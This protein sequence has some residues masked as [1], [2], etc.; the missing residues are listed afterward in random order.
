MT[1]ILNRVGAARRLRYS[2][3]W[4]LL[5]SKIM[6]EAIGWLKVTRKRYWLPC[7]NFY[8]EYT[9]EQ[10]DVILAGFGDDIP[11]VQVFKENLQNLK[12]R[13]TS[14]ERPLFF[15]IAKINIILKEQRIEQRRAIE[16]SREA[17]Q[18][19]QQPNQPSQDG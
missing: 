3:E 15:K 12:A 5:D 8:R 14:N 16:E 18:L 10:W 1:P 4:F 7:A 13:V 11:D 19:N 17:G 6:I 2:E 9:E